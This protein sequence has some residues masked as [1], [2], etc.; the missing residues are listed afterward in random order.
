MLVPIMIGNAEA[1]VI[2]PDTESACK[3]PIEAAD[4][5]MI[6][7]NIAPTNTPR[8]GFLSTAKSCS[9]CGSSASGAIFSCIS[10]IPVKRIPMPII[11]SPTFFVLFF[12]PTII[13]IRPITI[14]IEEKFDGL[15][16][17][18][19]AG[20]LLSPSRFVSLS[21]CVVMVVPIFAPMIIPTAPFSFKRPAFTS[22]TTITVVADDDCTAAVTNAPKSIPENTFPVIFA[23]TFSISPPEAFSSPE[24]NMVIPYK[25]RPSPPAIPIMLKIL[26]SIHSFSCFFHCTTSEHAPAH[27][28]TYLTFTPILLNK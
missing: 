1:N 23:R 12:L 26:K 3:M 16:S 20:P 25:N 11:I 4:D 2:A 7:V 22:P 17:C 14:S 28:I 21:I 24:L 6:A 9:N 18:N 19:K 10:I 27:P 5:C 13:I 15:Q 8:T